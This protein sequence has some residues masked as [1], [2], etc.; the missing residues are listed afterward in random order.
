MG[1]LERQIAARLTG[2]YGSHYE[3]EP[4]V[5]PTPGIG[6]AVVRL[7][8]SGVCHGDVYSRDGGGPAPREPVRPLTGGHEGAGVIIDIG[9]EVEGHRHVFR[10]G[11]VVGIAWRH[12]ACGKCEACL[13][14]CDNFCSN[15]LVNGLHR[16]GT[17]Q[18]FIK[19]P[20]NRL[21]RIPAGLTTEAACPILCAGVTPFAALRKMNPI[22]GEW[23]AIVGAAGALG[24]LAIQFAKKY[25]KL[26]VI[27]IDGG[28]SEKESF[29]RR[30][31]CDE[32]V[33]FLKEGDGLA[34]EVLRRTAGGVRYALLLSPHQEAYD[35]A[36]QYMRFRGHVMA[37]GIG[38][39]HFPL[40]P[41]ITNDLTVSSSNNGT[42][43]D[44]EDALKATLSCQI[45]SVTEVV[46][47]TKLDEALDRV[48]QGRV[49]GKLVVQLSA[50]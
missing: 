41:I 17:F 40:R 6:E 7:H 8:M 13:K 19:V 44:I 20:I 28:S 25:F 2:P 37:I 42:L 34:N 45:Q 21:V 10:E 18:S 30:L 4:Q 12:S 16:D 24:H 1:S 5:R 33:D 27:G 29:C 39:C 32:Y 35:T 48:K 14:D 36:G 50:N 31:G 46:D 26:R 38:N 15:Q 43:E 22:E 9:A 23:C 47:I 3:F 11:D 49:M